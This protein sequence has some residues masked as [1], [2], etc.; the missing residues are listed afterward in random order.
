MDRT[1]FE[2]GLQISPARAG[3]PEFE[4]SNGSRRVE[5]NWPDSLRDSTSYR[6]T[7]NNRIADRRGN[8]LPEPVTFAF[9]TGSQVDRGEIRG[10]VHASGEKSGTFDVFAYRE[11]SLTDTFWLSL[12]DYVTQTGTG[13]HFQLP[14]LRAGTYRLLVLTD[15]N[16]NQ[17]LDHGEQFAVSTRDFPVTDDLPPDSADWFPILF[18]TSAFALRNCA[19]TIPG[20]IALAFSHPIDTA[21]ASAWRIEV[22]DSATGLPAAFSVLNPTLRRPS[23]ISLLGSWTTEAVY[24]VAVSN[25]IDQRG[26][27]LTGDTCYLKYSPRPDSQPPKIE[28]VTLPT[29]EAGMTSKDP[30]KWV[31]T[32]PMDTA[33]VGGALNVRDTLGAEVSGQRRWVDLQTLAFVPDAPWGDTIVVVATI[34]STRISDAAGNLALTGTYSWKFTPLA[35]ARMGIAEVTIET[36]ASPTVEIW[37]EA[38]SISDPRISSMAAPG[39][40]V[41]AMPLPAGRWQLGGFVDSNRDGRWFP[42]RVSPFAFSERRVIHSDTLDVRARFTL[43]DIT[44]K[45]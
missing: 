36:A 28:S 18:D 25:L 7:L 33:R 3:S 35:D 8:K 23:L 15:A 20:V 37:I 43:E 45:F 16:R 31:F 34:D 19:A 44:L 26:F 21:G 27:E 40:G 14:F 11:E 41:I 38:R 12:P 2:A 32:E 42:G 9:S 30:I 5:I 22:H 4:W 1:T 17:R 10:F 13:G 6:I 24:E 39:P 29:P